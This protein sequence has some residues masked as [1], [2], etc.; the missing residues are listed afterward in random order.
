MPL[1]S[2][3]KWAVNH[4]V[5]HGRYTAFS[6]A[7]TVACHSA[8]SALTLSST[9][10]IQ[11]AQQQPEEDEVLVVIVAAPEQ[12]QHSDSSLLRIRRRTRTSGTSP[13]GRASP[14]GGGKL[15]AEHTT[16]ASPESEFRR[17]NEPG[18]AVAKAQSSRS[19]R[20]SPERKAAEERRE[21][22]LNRLVAQDVYLHEKQ[23]S[24]PAQIAEADAMGFKR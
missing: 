6:H 17:M 9:A 3:G 11:L 13:D 18:P 16:G 14:P 21:G 1:Q 15:A 19:R 5:V 20:M 12:P 4:R 7:N 22:L 8:A 2:S 24:C 10:C 23:V